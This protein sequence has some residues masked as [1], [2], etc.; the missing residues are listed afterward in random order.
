MKTVRVKNNLILS[1]K[2]NIKFI[3]GPCQ[4]ESSKHAF[5]VC[6][7]ISKLAKKL[8]FEFI[9]K[10]SFDKANRSSH[11]SKRG[12]GIKNGMKI[13]SKIKDKFKCPVI[14]DIHEIEQIEIAKKTLDIIQ[15]PAFLCRQTQFI[16]PS[17]HNLPILF[18]FVKLRKSRLINKKILLNN[19]NNNILLL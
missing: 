5:E 19:N 9:Y 2:S 14:S 6:D 10:S 8:N 1:N 11:K 12:V 13:L 4:I 16:S 3:L 7:E 15:I 18:G 17:L